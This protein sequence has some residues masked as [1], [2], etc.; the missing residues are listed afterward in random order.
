MLELTRRAKGQNLASVY[1]VDMREELKKGNRSIISDSLKELME[2]R[3]QKHQQIMLFLNRRGYAG[4]VSCRAC[5]YVVKCPHCDVSLSAHRGGKLVCHYCGYETKQMNRCPECGSGYIGGF[6]A[7]TQQIEEL[8]KQDVSAGW[9]A[10]DGS[11]YN[12]I[13]GRT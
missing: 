10:S 1:V 12:K 3:L 7:G 8:I 13:K 5:G 9:R 11:G 2:D 4:F 6:K